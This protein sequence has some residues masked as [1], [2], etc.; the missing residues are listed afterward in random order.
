MAEDIQNYTKW[1]LVGGRIQLTE[2]AI[3]RYFKCQKRNLPP[4]ERAAVAKLE[5]KRIINEIETKMELEVPDEVQEHD[6][7]DPQQIDIDIPPQRNV[8]EEFSDNHKVDHS[9]Q[10]QK[11]WH[12]YRSVGIQVNIQPKMDDA[13]V[14]PIVRS[15]AQKKLYPI[16]LP[17]VYN[18]SETDSQQTS[19]STSQSTEFSLTQCSQSSDE[20]NDDKKRF[21]ALVLSNI[22]KLCE[23]YPRLF[24]GVPVECFFLLEI[25]LKNCNLTR[26]HL[27][28]TL[29]KIRIN[30]S[31]SIL[32]I[33]FGISEGQASRAFHKTLPILYEVMKH[34]IIQFKSEDILKNLPIAFRC[35]Y[36]K[37][38]NIIDCFEIEIE[39]P[40]D[41]L[42]QSLTYSS[43]KHCN[44][45]KYLI[46]STPNG[47]VNFIS[48]GYG[49]RAS[50]LAITQDCTF[51]ETLSQGKGVMADRG[52][53]GIDRLSKKKKC[54][55]IR[56]P[57]VYG[58]RK[59]SKKQVVKTRQI[60]SLRIHIERVIRRIRE[61]K[62]LVPHS[63]VDIHLVK[64]LDQI[65]T[66]VC[67]LINLQKKIVQ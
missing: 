37:T 47:F 34:F 59:C 12:H 61:F 10:T 40:S 67:G 50:D 23:M 42:H 6:N 57:S 13:N 35:N 18:D 55:L 39:K 56:P 32:G 21:L 63:C 16:K 29:C 48:R 64:H 45:V 26:K 20:I 17:V 25:I 49:G 66:I 43:Y 1:K 52:F 9:T 5:R 58:N 11:R 53:K 51:L 2:N 33:F 54:S 46:S 4:I 44:T 28:L 41:S 3:P 14:S 30:L 8:T 38:E 24:L 19:Q 65:V 31:F 62:I 36:S 22:S 15:V 60:A 7:M 27:Y